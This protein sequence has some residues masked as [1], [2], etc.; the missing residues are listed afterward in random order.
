MDPSVQGPMHGDPNAH[1]HVGQQFAGRFPHGML[2]GHVVP[3]EFGGK[4]LNSKIM[5]NGAVSVSNFITI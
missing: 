4:G 5:G 3:P 1:G 2:Q